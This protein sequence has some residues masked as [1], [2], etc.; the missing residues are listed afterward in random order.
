MAIMDI[1]VAVIQVYISRKLLLLLA[2]DSEAGTAY[3]S[4]AGKFNP[5]FC[6][7]TSYCSILRYIT[8]YHYVWEFGLLTD[9]CF[10]TDI[11]YY[12]Y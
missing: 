4:S 5:G 2:D 7:V 6:G 1:S 10:G 8:N 9:I 12:I 11:S 3:P